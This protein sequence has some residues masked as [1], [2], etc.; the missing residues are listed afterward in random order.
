MTAFYLGGRSIG[1]A[2]PVLANVQAS[3]LAE[4]NTKLGDLTA[5]MAAA[6]Q[7]SVSLA[8]IPPNIEASI[9]ILTSAIAS[10][11]AALTNPVAALNITVAAD[12][13]LL[14][15][16]QIA[17]LEVSLSVALELGELLLVGGLHMYL[18]EGAI[19]NF[20]NDLQT[21]LSSGMPGGSGPTQE[22]VA[23]VLL[24]GSPVSIAALRTV[25]GQ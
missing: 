2:I 24:A 25:F 3:L 20:G 22:G 14:I 23:F 1:S 16:V 17:A 18:C 6:V 13:L 4:L 8:V 10:A 5:R 9:A 11:S 12:L 19:G 7:M 21:Q 15:G